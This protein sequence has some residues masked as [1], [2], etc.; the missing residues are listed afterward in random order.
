MNELSFFEILS[1]TYFKIHNKRLSRGAFWLAMIF[2]TLVS[3]ALFPVFYIPSTPFVITLFLHGAYFLI[4]TYSFFVM[5]INRFHDLDHTGWMSLFFFIPIINIFF[6]LYLLLK[7]GDERDN[8]FGD[9]CA[10]S[11]SQFLTKIYPSLIVFA[12][13]YVVLTDFFQAKNPYTMVFNLA[14]NKEM[15]NSLAVISVDEEIIPGGF[16]TEDRLIVQ[17][18]RFHSIVQDKLSK[19]VDLNVV[20]ADGVQTQIKRFIASDE[21]SGIAVF[22]VNDP[23]GVPGY[24]GK[25]NQEMLEKINAFE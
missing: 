6:L 18:K 2:S 20:N 12:T 15:R 25:S 5:V 8:A 9:P 16:I 22:E 3:I 21:A 24:L 19:N 11:S 23:I 1:A 10:F 13:C 4:F 14:L 17:G 7:Q